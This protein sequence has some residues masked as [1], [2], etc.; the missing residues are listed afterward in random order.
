MEVLLLW[1]HFPL[2]TIGELLGNLQRRPTGFGLDDD[3]DDE[4]EKEE[5]ELI[6]ITYCLIHCFHESLN[7]QGKGALLPK[8]HM[9]ISTPCLGLLALSMSLPRSPLVVGKVRQSS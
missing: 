2:G 6:F 4:R 1:G 5:G 3:D 7:S 9:G 8:C